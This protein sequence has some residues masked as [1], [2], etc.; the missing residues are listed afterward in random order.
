[1]VEDRFRRLRTLLTARRADQ[2]A[3]VVS[4]VCELCVAELSISGAGATVVSHLPGDESAGME[5]GL[6]YA[7]N[8][9]SAGLEDLQLT[10]NEGPCLDAFASGGPVLVADLA[11]E[12]ARWPAFTPAACEL[13]AAAVFSFPLQVGVVR[14]GSLDLYR[15]ET[16][17]LGR[18]EMADALVLADLATQGVV[19]DLDGH[20]VHDL[21]WLADPHLELHQAA[22]MVQV[23]LGSTT[24]VA[25]LRLRAHAFSSGVPLAEVARQVVARTLR[26]TEGEDGP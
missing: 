11:A 20:D 23:Q 24:E 3:S 18:V 13:G 17:P 4:L 26:F 8:P 25:L 22:G 7:T 10:V 15:D 6:V 1:M 12:G 2:S 19:A 21:S 5:R 16:G 14:L 9:V